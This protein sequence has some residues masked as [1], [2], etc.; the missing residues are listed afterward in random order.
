MTDSC[1]QETHQQC[2]CV[3]LPRLADPHVPQTRARHQDDPYWIYER[4]WA[5]RRFN[6]PTIQPDF[7]LNSV[8]EGTVDGGFALMEAKVP[9]VGSSADLTVALWIIL[10]ETRSDPN[11][12]VELAELLDQITANPRLSR[13]QSWKH[14]PRR[15]TKASLKLRTTGNLQQTPRPKWEE[16]LLALCEKGSED[17]NSKTGGH[18]SPLEN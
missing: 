13:H 3:W 5:T 2:N 17:F 6:L 9:T 7:P 4:W 18:M 11:L 15:H 14:L 10:T 1:I 8:H 12:S 16:K